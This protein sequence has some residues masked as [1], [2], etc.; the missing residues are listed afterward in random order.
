VLIIIPSL[1]YLILYYVIFV[2]MIHYHPDF[3]ISI[4]QVP[5][6]IGIL[7]LVLSLFI[8][9]VSDTISLRIIRNNHNKEIEERINEL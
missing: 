6:R 3:E 4:L 7:L 2:A 9:V 8:Y 1:I 5:F